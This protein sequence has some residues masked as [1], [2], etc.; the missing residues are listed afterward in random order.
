[1]GAE[2]AT[3]RF[4]LARLPGVP[5]HQSAEPRVDR[6]S[7]RT[8]VVWDAL[9]ALLDDLRRDTG[10]NALDVVDVGGGT[11]GFAVPLAAAGHRVTVV[12]AS[13]DALASL[14]RR[15][16]EAGASDRID[17]V[18]ADAARVADAVGANSADLVL[19]HGVLEHVDDPAAVVAGV[20][21]ALRPGGAVSVLV[22]QPLAAVL[23]RVVTGRLAEASRLLSAP[24]PALDDRDPRPRRLDAE[25]V[26]ALLHAEGL[27]AVATHG[28][29]VFTDLVPAATVD[30]DTDA[31]RTLLA[32]E[33]L[34]SEHPQ[35]L[36]LAT[37]LHVVARRAWGDHLLAGD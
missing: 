6:A 15:A 11:G 5:D 21:A 3:E 34:A 28:V 37:Q 31:T 19:C 23:H 25:R 9:D 29:R 35:L 26:R 27:Q 36:D 10:R 1:M 14:R 4:L 33:R 32:L 17:A 20:A 30:G 16:G 12:D 18:Q 13:P 7:V 8:A 22:A 2:E 24:G